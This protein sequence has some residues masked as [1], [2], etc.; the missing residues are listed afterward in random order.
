[1]HCNIR[2]HIQFVLYFVNAVKHSVQ[3]KGERSGL[4]IY[5][6]NTFKGESSSLSIYVMNT[7]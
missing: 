1:M 7:I 5:V 2:S 6:I 3:W 4:S